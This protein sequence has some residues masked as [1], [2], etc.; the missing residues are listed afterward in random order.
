MGMPWLKGMPFEETNYLLCEVTDLISNS[1]SF[2]LPSP[3][4][5][6][7]MSEARCVPKPHGPKWTH[8]LKLV[9]HNATNVEYVFCNLY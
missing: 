8:T 5:P 3:L 4:L 9:S 6:L 7:T 1:R 2:S